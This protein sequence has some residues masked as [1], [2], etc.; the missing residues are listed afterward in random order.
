MAQEFNGLD[1]NLRGF[2]TPSGV[3]S[4]ISRGY[5]FRVYIPT[6]DGSGFGSG[7]GLLTAWARSAKLPAYKLSTKEIDFQ[8]QKI[9]IAGPAEFDGNWDVEFLLDESHSLRHAFLGWMQATYDANK[10]HHTA[11]ADYKRNNVRIEQVSKNGQTVS[12]Y[13][14]VGVF[15]SNVSEIALEQGSTEPEKFTVSLSYDYFVIG[16]GTLNVDAAANDRS[17]SQA[18]IP[19]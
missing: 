13:N 15:P 2:F 17:G 6:V 1:N 19:E 14:F 7:P 16:I 12:T 10:M 9:R 5:L 3:A 11:P 8:G 4:D 18:S